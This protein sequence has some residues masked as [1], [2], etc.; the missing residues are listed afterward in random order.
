MPSAGKSPTV[1]PPCKPFYSQWNFGFNL[2]WE[3][4]FWGRFR[5]AIESNA[6]SLDASV[7]DYDETL[8]TLLGDVATYYAQMRTLEKRIEYTKQN[9]RLQ[10]EP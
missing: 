6:A 4:D 7:A 10:Q 8:V 1:R 3:L 9:V 2:N 5:R